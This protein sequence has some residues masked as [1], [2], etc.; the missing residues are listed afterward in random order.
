MYGCGGW[1]IDLVCGWGLG[2]RPCVWVEAGAYTLCMSIDLRKDSCFSK[3]PCLC[4]MLVCIALS[5]LH[6]EL[7]GQLYTGCDTIDTFLEFFLC[8]IPDLPHVIWSISE[9]LVTCQLK[10]SCLHHF[11]LY[12]FIGG[13]VL[14]TTRTASGGYALS[15]SVKKRLT[16]AS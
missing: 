9:L 3:A 12:V 5:T 15:R 6:S 2:H 16:Q 8:G 14:D 10:W 7:Q 4:V 1:G 13:T 11:L